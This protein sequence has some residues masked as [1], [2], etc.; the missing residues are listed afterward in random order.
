VG[1]LLQHSRLVGRGVRPRLNL[2]PGRG[3]R[4][5]PRLTA[6]GSACRSRFVGAGWRFR[7]ETAHV[8]RALE[9]IAATDHRDPTPR[10]R[11]HARRSGST[12]ISRLGQA[13]CTSGGRPG[14][15]PGTPPS[16]PAVTEPHACTELD[17]PI[18]AGTAASTRA[19]ADRQRPLL[20]PDPWRLAAAV[21][22][23]RRGLSGNG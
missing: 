13:R 16:A 22:R 1:R 20:A 5:R 15:R 21:S 19:R 2:W 10:V 17:Q 12:R 3:K 8:R 11:C 14:T 23:S 18:W 9:L 6:S 4:R 7:R